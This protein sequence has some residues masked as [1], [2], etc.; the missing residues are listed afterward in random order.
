MQFHYQNIPFEQKKFEQKLT[1]RDATGALVVGN[2][3]LNLKKIQIYFN[4][5]LFIVH[6]LQGNNIFLQVKVLK[7]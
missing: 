2:R 7:M 3:R 6:S 4:L 1:P 5:I